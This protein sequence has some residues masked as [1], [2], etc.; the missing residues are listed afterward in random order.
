MRAIGGAE[1][2][3][4]LGDT[5]KEKKARFPRA[6]QE[7]ILLCI[8]QPILQETSQSLAFDFF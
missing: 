1:I 7:I 3:G 2:L 6:G 5:S 4:G 8:K